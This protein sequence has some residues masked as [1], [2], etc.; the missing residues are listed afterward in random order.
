MSGS[1]EVGS[2]HFAVI[3]SFRGFRRAVVSEANAS[4]AEGARG[5]SKAMGAGGAKAG[6]DTGRGFSSAFKQSVSVAPALKAVEREVRAASQVLSRARLSEADA[7]GRVRVAEAQLAEARAKF[8]EGS[9][10]VIR[11]EERLASVQRAQELQSEKLAAATTRLASAKADLA[12][13]L[14]RSGSAVSR[15]SG[16]LGSAKQV[17]ADFV[18]GFR[19]SKAAESAFTGAAGAAG[20]LARMVSGPLVAAVEAGSMA[21]TNFRAGFLDARSAASGLTGV[22]GSLGGALR[23]ALQPSIAPIANFVAGLRSADAAGSAL[24]GR[25]GTLGGVVGSATARFAA[26]FRDANAAGS[27][28]TG[29]MGS[30]GGVA[31]RSLAPVQAGLSQVRDV[32]AKFLEPLRPAGAL[33]GQ[34]GSSAVSAGR[35]IVGA[36]GQVGQQVAER[37]GAGFRA[38]VAAAG[39]AASAI[40]SAFSNVL[41]AIGT[42]AVA[43]L[44]A[45]LKGGFDRL[46]SVENATARMRGFGI[47]AGVVNSVMADVKDSVQ[48][49]IYTVGEMGNA[50]AQALIAGIKPGQQL[51]SY[52]GFLKNAATA[53]N[54]PLNE[55]NEIMGKI[56]TSAGGPVRE[57]LQQLA[58]RNIPV[59]TTLAEKMGLSVEEVKKLATEGKITSDVIVEHLGGAIERMAE[60]VGET[61]EASLVKM[62]SS[63]SRFGEVLLAESFP[64]VK[65]VADGVREIMN[66]AIA[67]VAPIKQALGL[68]QVGPAIEWI[69]QLTER[70]RAFRELIT[71]G[72][73]EGNSALAGIVD[74]VKELAPLFGAAA[75]AVIPL[76][77][78]FLGSL[79]VIGP[80]LAGLGSS[81][82]G[83]LAPLL[84]AG[85]L[86]AMLGLSPDAFAGAVM[87]LVGA[88][89]SGF[90]SLAQTLPG[91][92]AELVPT[93]AANLVANAPVLL[94]GMRQLLIGMVQAASSAIPVIVTSVISLVPAIVQALVSAIPVLLQTGVQLLL[95][96]VQAATVAIPAIVSAV[97]AAV[98]QIVTAIVT[99]LPLIIQGGLQLFMGL[100]QALVTLIP[101]LLTAVID[102]VPVLI[103]GLLSM[104]PQL[105]LGALELFLGLVM[106]LLQALPQIVVAII[107]AIPQLITALISQIPLMIT[108]A[109]QLFL[110]L[111]TG[112]LQALPQIISAVIG[113]IPQIVGALIRA[114]PQLVQAGFDLIRGLVNGIMN[115]APMVLD[116]IG[117][118]VSGAIDWAKSLLGIKSPS[119]VFRTIGD[120]VGQGLAGG[121]DGSQSRVASAAGRLVEATRS[122]FDGLEPVE[123]PVA[124]RVFEGAGLAAAAA[125]RAGV[126]ASSPVEVSLAGLAVRASIDGNPFTLLIEEQIDAALAP[127]GVGAATSRLGLAR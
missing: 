101:M 86:V 66:L 20:G 10:Q 29:L 35:T 37:L 121:L 5:F 41:G 112:L 32:A 75:L 70:V 91:L 9:S 1:Y 31:A 80:M 84:A 36:M 126:M 82:V 13:L 4:G 79:P 58:N 104:L 67:L 7:A 2:G 44:I 118:V 94:E 12:A 14:E 30:L 43:G 120:Q 71:S 21:L 19:D 8:G 99:A 74:R 122:A 98:P 25:M 62:R 65:A 93:I 42:G 6:R 15:L 117:G 63:F 27:S 39:S 123:I 113:M 56:V 28:F 115:A 110:G 59:W 107:E 34:I 72:S 90:S 53:A 92:L 76:M 45:S 105:I 46:A 106:G 83:G 61:T 64:G 78:S 22:A 69:N 89:S 114:I 33:L 96:L 85:G 111:I 16:V 125:A 38:A 54:A 49:T 3:P 11:A 119:R 95:G 50:A 60:E 23:G 57:E 73:A 26:G 109:I 51:N 127:F 97:I 102:M 47:E 108:G 68:D 24:T 87:G 40:G 77:G 52:M 81:L 103:G 116:A 124:A 17:V 18:A 48:G 88:L 55:I 100:L